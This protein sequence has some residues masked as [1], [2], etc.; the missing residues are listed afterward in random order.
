MGCSV[1][2]GE[3]E[4]AQVLG[5][6]LLHSLVKFATLAGSELAANLAGLHDCT[7]VKHAC[8]TE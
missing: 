4:V 5:L 6:H 7:S 2:V 3:G 8:T 1:D